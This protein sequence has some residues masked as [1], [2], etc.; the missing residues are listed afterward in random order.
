MT[1]RANTA[2]FS[3]LNFHA[4]NVFSPCELGIFD[5]FAGLKIPNL[6]AVKKHFAHEILCQ[7][8]YVRVKEANA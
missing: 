5:K 2:P 6:H 4:S 7:R 1:I 8:K 3:R